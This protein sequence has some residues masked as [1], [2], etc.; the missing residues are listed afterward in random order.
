M[1][2]YENKTNTCIRRYV[3]LSYS[4]NRKAPTC[5]GRLMWPSLGRCYTQD[6]LQIYI[7]IYNTSFVQQLPED[8]HKG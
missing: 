5:F 4:K 8:G 6:I 3:N 7:T 2:Y 1:L